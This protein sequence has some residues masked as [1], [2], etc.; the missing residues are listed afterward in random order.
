VDAALVADRQT[1]LFS[2]DQYVRYFGYDHTTVDDGYPKSIGGALPGELGPP[3][4]PDEFA[5]GLDAAFRT[6]DGQT[7]LIKGKQFILRR[8]NPRPRWDWA[9]RAVFAALVRRFAR[10]SA[11]PPPGHPGHDRGLASPPRAPRMDLPP[12]DRTATDR[13][14][15]SPP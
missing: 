8:T 5:D 12:P 3:P 15:G 2:G 14:I 1:Y 13:R 10:R 7:Y 4:L 11:V 6:P 9:D